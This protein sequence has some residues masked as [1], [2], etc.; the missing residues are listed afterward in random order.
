MNN[1][2]DK[3]QRVLESCPKEF[4]SWINPSL[5]LRTTCAWVCQACHGGC[6]LALAVK[7]ETPLEVLLRRRISGR[8]RS[9]LPVKLKWYDNPKGFASRGLIQLLNTLSW[10][11]SLLEVKMEF[12]SRNRDWRAPRPESQ[13]DF[14]ELKVVMSKTVRLERLTFSFGDFHNS[15]SVVEWPTTLV[16]LDLC[17]FHGSIVGAKWPRA[18]KELYMYTWSGSL[19]GTEFPDSL[20]VLS[21]RD[22]S[23][24]LPL[25]GVKWKPVKKLFMVYFNKY[26]DDNNFIEWPIG[27]EELY[28]EKYNHP[29]D[30]VRW[31]N[32]LKVLYF[33]DWW[34][35]PLDDV[36]FPDS[37]EDLGLGIN[38]DQSLVGVTWPKSLKKLYLGAF[39]GSLDGIVWP[40][41]LEELRMDAVCGD[42]EDVTWPKS[43]KKICL[44]FKDSFHVVDGK[45]GSIV[46]E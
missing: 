42:I 7:E 11:D 39:Q 31:P 12:V 23:D 19:S 6:S 33:G 32:T 29:I 8:V 44:D 1:N 27:L 26:M 18:L 14:N 43:L 37:L 17:G 5:P 35:E 21:V 3:L 24:E 40:H 2:T 25:V 15:I 10:V 45:V 20:E 13:V 28:L 30:D 41:K 38:F 9:I 46:K 16:R 36:K 22:I 34:N 4:L